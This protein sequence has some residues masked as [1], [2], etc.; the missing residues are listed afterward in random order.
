MNESQCEIIAELSQNV[1][2]NAIVL[3]KF[4]LCV[5][6][7][8]AVLAQWKKLGVRF[9]VHENSKILFQFYY[10]LN[11]V[12]SLDYGVLYLTEFVRLRFDCFLFD[13][14]TII[15]LRG[16]GISSFV[17][18]H[19]VIVIMT[20]ERLYSSLFPAR[21]ERHSHRLFAVSLG[22]IAVCTLT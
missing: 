17:S 22:L 2:Y 19:H 11:I 8:V 5:V 20:F 1:A 4:L 10:V 12:L 13:F 16:L 18:A 21:F 3:A 15:I 9:L 7:G 14:R 6:G